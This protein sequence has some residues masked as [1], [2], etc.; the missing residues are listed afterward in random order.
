MCDCIFQRQRSFSSQH[1]IN[2]NNKDDLFSFLHLLIHFSTFCDWRTVYFSVACPCCSTLGYYSYSCSE[3]THTRLKKSERLNDGRLLCKTKAAVEASVPPGG[4]SDTWF[5][6]NHTISSLHPY[7]A[8]NKATSRC[9]WHWVWAVS[10]Q[11]N[12]LWC[13]SSPE[14]A[15]NETP[16]LHCYLP[17]TFLKG[18]YVFKL[19]DWILWSDAGVPCKQKR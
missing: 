12:T 8:S 10:P 9:F 2:A 16:R 17:G 15:H 7:P 13:S 19:C 3:E 11:L 1:L 4:A 6:S 18:H 5:I 14:S